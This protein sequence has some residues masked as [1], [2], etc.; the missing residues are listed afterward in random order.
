MYSKRLKIFFGFCLFLVI[1]CLLRLFTMQSGGSR[2]QALEVIDSMRNTAPVQ[3]PTLRGKIVDRHGKTLAVDKP[4][5]FIYVNYR[6]TRLLDDNW[7]FA[8]L[9]RKMARG[10]EEDT[11]RAQLQEEFADDIRDLYKLIDFCAKLEGNSEAEIKEL[12]QKINDRVWWLRSYIAWRK[13]YPGRDF[14]Q[15]EE[16]VPSRIERIK[17]AASE[18]I[19]EMYQNH[20]LIELTGED[21]MFAAEVAFADQDLIEVSAK[22]VRSYPFGPVASQ[23]IG[24]VK[25]KYDTNDDEIAKFLLD[26]PLGSYQG[27]ELAGFKG[28]EWVCEA[29]LR[30]R[31]GRV[32]HDMDGN[33]LENTPTRFGSDVKLTIDIELQSRIEQMLTDPCA[34][35]GFYDGPSAA[36]VIDVP[37][38]EVL[39]AASVPRFDLNMARENYKQYYLDD[40]CKPYLNRALEKLYPAGSTI[41][42][43]IF[44]AANA[45]G[46][47]S[48]AAVI[49]CPAQTAPRGWPSCWIW[50]QFDSCHD[51]QFSDGAGNNAR[52]AIKG[53]CNIY[54][55]HAA[56]K[57]DSRD[58]QKWFYNFGFGRRLLDSPDFDSVNIAPDDMEKLGRKLDE[59]AGVIWTGFAQSKDLEL[60]EMP[61]IRARDK[62]FFGIGQAD[63]RTTVLQVANEMATIA[64]GGVFRQ[65]RLFDD[66]SPGRFISLGISRA[67]IATVKEGMYAVVNEY[68]G[69]ARRAFENTDY[70]AAG[71]RVYGK[72]GSTQNP[73]CAWFAGFFE[74][75]RGR[76][77]AMAVVVENGQ[78]GAGDAGPLGREIIEICRRAGY[79]GS[80]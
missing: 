78:S 67:A 36:V 22:S 23:I 73:S 4:S 26:D 54:F 3:L 34:N 51:Y 68:Q 15:F 52:N 24:W 56:D 49:S 69:T 63:M 21:D 57:L 7:Q 66:N 28:A 53:S 31:R 16:T 76:Q 59:S 45:E 80:E 14:S 75:N 1:I 41:K 35:P 60:A 47:L 13:Y 32:H 29:Y 30:G 39:A 65:V 62:R 43:L 5:Y 42:P 40:P 12:I 44:I 20:S 2:A 72:T 77:L 50:R 18:S 48:S 33:L 46:L 70:K 37:T 9:I 11:A 71:L 8:K 27:Q 25:P 6:L 38:G 55:S 64:R 19:I 61:P 10:V 17:L 74:D 58:L 79:V